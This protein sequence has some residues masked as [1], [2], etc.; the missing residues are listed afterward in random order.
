MAFVLQDIIKEVEESRSPEP[1]KKLKKVILAKVA[2]H[3]RI[4]P[5]A[6]AKKSHILDLI[7]DHCVENDIID[8]VEENPTAETTETAEVLQLKL[9]FEREEAQRAHDAEKSLQH[10][11]LHNL[12]KQKKL[13]I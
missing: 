11:L 2:A 13:E 1:L 12:Q 5:A 3:Y 10:Y 7:E 4:T 6:S 8:V 9:E